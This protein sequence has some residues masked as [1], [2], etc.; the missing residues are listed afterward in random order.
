M[1]NWMQDLTFGAPSWLWALAA[2]PALA[3]LFA[4]AQRQA[5]RRLA[6][7]LATPRLRA[8][9]TG[10]AS[11]ARR[12]WRFALLLLGLAALTVTLAEPRLGYEMRETHRRGLDVIA[13]VDVSKSMLAT[14]IAPSRLGRA[15]LALHDLADQLPGDRLGLIAFAGTAF[16]QAPLTGDYDAVLNAGGEL[17]TDLIPEGGTNIGGAIDLAIEAFGKGAVGNRAIVLMTDGEPTA[18]TDQADGLKA[19][20]RAAEAGVKI[21]TV[22]FGTADGSLI[23]L[24]GDK[25]QDY[26]R[27]ADGQLVR[28]RLNE[29][30]LSD[31]ARA[32]GGFYVHL[33]NGGGAIRKV[34]EEGLAR[35]KTGEID[36]RSARRPIERYQWPLGFA[37][38]AL[39]AGAFL[40]ERRKARAP[41][42]A[43]AAPRPAMAAAAALALCCL[44]GQASRAADAASDPLNLYQSGHYDE[45]YHA[46]E[47][48]AGKNPDQHSFDFD[49]GASAYRGKQYGEALDAFAKALTSNDPALQAKANYNFGNSL[50]RR[51]QSQKDK[52]ARITDWRNAIEHYNTTLN[53]LKA[54]PAHADPA[55]SANAAFNRDLVQRLL[56]EEKKQPQQQNKQDKQDKKQD[57]KDQ[58]DKQDSQSGQQPDQQQQQNQGDQQQQNQNSQGSSGQQQDQQQ[59]GQQ[60]KQDSSQSGGQSQQNQPPSPQSQQQQ[61]QQKSQ[62]NS[63]EKQQQGN[64]GNSQN[65]P[66]QPQQGNDGQ[67]PDS[68]D[69]GAPQ[70]PAPGQDQPRQRGDFK[71]QPSDSKDKPPEEGQAGQEGSEPPEQAGKMTPAQARALLES[72]KNEDQRVNLNADAE[73]QR[74]EQP[75]LKDW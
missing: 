66:P 44:A 39:T 45:A 58:Q 14:D 23:P 30:G 50:F 49:A 62:G 43:K 19:A 32:G 55:L 51:G 31:I 38:L 29:S 2:I 65:N 53:G 5:S 37:L 27:D 13:I 60:N 26:V 35:M 17:D 12:Q 75:V 73:K 4:W 22:G 34:V 28:T 36:A 8:Q 20:Q 68:H 6:A 16:L 48:L 7:L 3:L 63:G 54:D 42:A 18:D 41:V 72:L 69:S 61:Q 15:R 24:G 21:F 33:E 74:R 70:S 71:S 10:Q 64:Q 40:G 56:E 47:N 59:N 25:G 46:F 1:N 67:S 52:Q 9:L 11:V 57:Q